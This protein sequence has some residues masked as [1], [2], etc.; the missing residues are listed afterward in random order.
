[1]FYI[2]TVFPINPIWNKQIPNKNESLTD[3]DLQKKVNNILEHT[4]TQSTNLHFMIILAM[5]GKV[6]VRRI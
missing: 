5:Y 3:K 1:M 2:S 4:F 6:T